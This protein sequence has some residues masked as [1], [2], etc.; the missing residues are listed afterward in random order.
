MRVTAM[1][2]ATLLILPG[3]ARAQHDPYAA[4][5]R[6][7]NAADEAVQL[8]RRLQEALLGNAADYNA[9]VS[10]LTSE[11]DALAD[12]T[13]ILNN[14]ISFRKKDDLA[15]WVD[16]AK[17]RWGA[18]SGPRIRIFNPY[19]LSSYARYY[20]EKGNLM[21]SEVRNS[22]EY[23]RQQRQDWEKARRR[24]EEAADSLE[25]D[26]AA[27][28]RQYGVVQAAQSDL[29]AAL[30]A[31]RRR[32]NDFTGARENSGTGSG[33]GGLRGRVEQPRPR[34]LNLAGRTGK[35]VWVVNGRT[36]YFTYEFQAGGRVVYR[37]NRETLDG[38]W[39]QS[40]TAV[41][42]QVGRSSEA[43]TLTGNRL[44]L[45][46]TTGGVGEGVATLTFDD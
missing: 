40:G 32:L 16:D 30:A 5:R 24:A 13:T 1:T 35:G 39:T 34:V 41:T 45:R 28:A 11:R 19:D 12:Q 3:F 10:R 46:C 44:V 14:V 25:R 6:E 38:S 27:A 7:A 33:S 9:D 17:K 20:D 18:E 8:Q 37:S 31:A 22:Y 43:G 42:V 36:T 2:L 21:V 23:L 29:A 15:R 4:A 26:Y